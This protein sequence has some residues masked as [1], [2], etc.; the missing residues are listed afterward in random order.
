MRHERS[1]ED[2]DNH[3][4]KAF[5]GLSLIIIGSLVAICVEAKSATVEDQYPGLATDVLKTVTLVTLKDG[6]ILTSGDLAFK[7]KEIKDAVKK[8]KKKMRRQLEKN[9]FFVLEEKAAQRL[10]LR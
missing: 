9:L 7:E 2:M 5:W 4:R 6:L 1:V 8:A 10:V 3:C